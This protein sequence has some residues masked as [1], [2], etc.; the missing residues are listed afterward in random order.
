M[1][2]PEGLRHEIITSF[3]FSMKAEAKQRLAFLAP[4]EWSGEVP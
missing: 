3:L 1:V 2:C 4:V